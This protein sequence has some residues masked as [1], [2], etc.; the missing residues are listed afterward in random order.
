MYNYALNLASVAIVDLPAKAVRS[1]S[2]VQDTAPDIPPYLIDLATQIAINSAAVTERWGGT[3]SSMLA[4]HST[5][6][7]PK[8]I[9]TEPSACRVKLRSIVIV[10]NCWL[11]RP[12]GLMVMRAPYFEYFLIA[13]LISLIARSISSSDKSL[14]DGGSRLLI[15]PSIWVVK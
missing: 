8:L 1:I 3:P 13:E 14:A 5:R 9:S 12:E 4:V 11:L 10:R 15:R 2:E 6:V 7:S